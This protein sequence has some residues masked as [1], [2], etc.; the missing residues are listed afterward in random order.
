[1]DTDQMFERVFADKL[2]RGHDRLVNGVKN[3]CDDVLFGGFSTV[4]IKVAKA[5]KKASDSC[6]YE[7]VFRARFG[8]P[9]KAQEIASCKLEMCRHKLRVSALKI[10]DQE[11]KVFAEIMQRLNA[12]VK[13]ED[14]CDT[15]L[16]APD[17]GH[18]ADR[19]GYVPYIKRHNRA[20]KA[21][22]IKLKHNTALY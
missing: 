19:K 17:V 1:M 22:Q 2:E 14:G 21:W 9:K 4:N 7:V 20:G 13:T 5:P 18:I 8:M 6:H 16:L 10:H 11:Q 3:R 12:F 15:L